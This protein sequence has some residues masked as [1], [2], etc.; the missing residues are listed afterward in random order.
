MSI[1]LE[2]HRTLLNEAF[3]SA[4]REARRTANLSQEALALQSGVDRTF[5]SML[6]RGIRQ[7][8]LATVW[9]LCEALS[10]N[11]EVLIGRTA[12]MMIRDENSPI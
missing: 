5:V 4:L 2:N 1:E 10:V 7:P 6:E 9:A 3:G 11:P 12:R 8:T